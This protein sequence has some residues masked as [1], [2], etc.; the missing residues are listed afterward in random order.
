MSRPRDF[1]ASASDIMLEFELG[2]YA[3]ACVFLI[4]A[5]TRRRFVKTRATVDRYIIIS[6]ATLDVTPHKGPRLPAFL[7]IPTPGFQ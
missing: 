2:G 1:K 5:D 4:T 6:V 7:F 3:P